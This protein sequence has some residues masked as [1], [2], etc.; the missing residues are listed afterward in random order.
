M[1]LTNLL[2]RKWKKEFPICELL[3]N[4]SH[5]VSEVSY[6]TEIFAIHGKIW[7]PTGVTTRK[8]LV[9]SHSPYA[10]EWLNSI[11]FGFLP[12]WMTMTTCSFILSLRT[13]FFNICPQK[14]KLAAILYSVCHIIKWRSLTTRVLELKYFLLRA[15]P[16]TGSQH[17]KGQKPPPPPPPSSPIP[18]SSRVIWSRL[19]MIMPAQ[20]FEHLQD[21][22]STT[23][24]SSLYQCSIVLRVK[25]SYI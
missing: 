20:V 4:Q 7:N 14:K 23:S 17:Q 1:K 15:V 9:L 3:M 12:E 16:T 2:D 11:F 21:G 24:L 13:L 5:L 19:L 10:T 18:S 22:H 6:W 8:H 25:R